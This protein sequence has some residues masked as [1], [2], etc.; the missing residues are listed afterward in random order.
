MEELFAYAKEQDWTD[1]DHIYA[2]EIKGDHALIIMEDEEHPM[3][4]P[5]AWSMLLDSPLFK[6]HESD[7]KLFRSHYNRWI[8]KVCGFSVKISAQVITKEEK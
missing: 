5:M 2:F 7:R 3:R 4:M 1:A 6:A 8:N